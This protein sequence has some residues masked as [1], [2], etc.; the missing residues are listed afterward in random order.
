MTHQARQT[1]IKRGRDE[2]YYDARS[3][4]VSLT[5][6]PQNQTNNAN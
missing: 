1:V 3:A 2:K 5:P 4:K 6:K